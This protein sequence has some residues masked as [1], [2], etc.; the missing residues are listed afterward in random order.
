MAFLCDFFLNLIALIGESAR[1]LGVSLNR[2]NIKKLVL[3]EYKSQKKQLKSKLSNKFVY[4]KM[5]ACTRQHHHVNY[6]GINVKYIDEVKNY[7]KTL[8][9]RDTQAQHPNKCL[10]QLEKDV[11]QDYGLQKYHVL[12]IVTDNSSNMVS[13]VKQVNER[14]SEG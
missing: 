3:Y 5:D 7:T 13:I 11:L 14:P 12:C 10:T 1:K 2:D 9:I 8:A 4:L 6:F